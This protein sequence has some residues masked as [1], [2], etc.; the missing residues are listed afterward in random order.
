MA[1][2]KQRQKFCFTTLEEYGFLAM[3]SRHGFS[4]ERVRPDFGH[5]QARMT[6]VDRVAVLAFSQLADA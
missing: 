3:L 6:F 5:N 2:G 1:D 4:E